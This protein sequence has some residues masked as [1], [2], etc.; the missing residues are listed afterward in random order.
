MKFTKTKKTIASSSLVMAAVLLISTSSA[1]LAQQNSP[2]IITNAPLPPELRSQ[3]YS[4]P[5][6]APAI[7]PMDL[8]GAA[9]FSPIDETIA[10]QKIESLRNDLFNLQT[11]VSELSRELTALATEGQ[12]QAATYYASV[13]T[14]STQLQ[15][16]TTPGNPRLIQRLNVARGNLEQL[17][18]NVS[19]LSD[20]AVDIAKVAS[21]S[22]FLL[23]SARATYSLSGAIEEDHVR[24]AQL[25]DSITNTVVIIDRLLNN[26]NDDLTRTTAYL[27]SER[28]NLRT[29]S[30]AINTG[31]LFGRSLAN[32]PFNSA[33]QASFTPAA[34][35]IAAL[36]PANFPNSEIVPSNVSGTF[37]APNVMA[38]VA[39]APIA[40]RP[41]MKVR[42]DRQDVSYE[43]PLYAVINEAMSRYPAARFELVAVHPNTGNPAKNAIESTRSRR[44]AER[45]LRTIS[46]VG[47][48]LQRVDLSY[49]PSNTATANEVHLY[50]R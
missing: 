20:L 9:Y 45:V 39:M 42:F 17:S 29:L 7:N 22:S 18:G 25:E 50:M 32:R 10:A 23:E 13:A 44:N 4:R 14:I 40:P 19:L 49:A 8:T 34:A 15:S 38:P 48:D 11:S 36:P 43:Q 35:S 1:A 41:L 30:L 46:E 31:D 2:L 27:S 16:G 3:V 6:V 21:I 24:L 33:P 28:N 37:M 47:V 5:S 26:V 12:T